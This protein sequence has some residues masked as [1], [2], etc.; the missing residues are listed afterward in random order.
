MEYR[1]AEGRYERLPQYGEE[2]VKLRVAVIAASI[3]SLL[4][5]RLQSL[6]DHPEHRRKC[7]NYQ[8]QDHPQGEQQT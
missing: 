7:Q 2:L 6:I 5:V 4:G 1:W 3:T 8:T